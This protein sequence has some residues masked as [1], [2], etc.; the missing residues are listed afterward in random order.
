MLAAYVGFKTLGMVGAVV[1]AVAV[2]LPSFAMMFA[3]L[4][5]FER[6]RTI[7]WARA[8]LQ[9]M[10]A[11]VIG[12]LA[13]TLT[14]LVPHALVDPFAVVLF[15]GAVTILLVWRAAPLKAAAGGAVLGVVRRRLI[16]A[17]GI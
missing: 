14:R 4:P 7:T 9:G 13:I 3:L 2:F 1:A 6:V 16:A 8:A 5:V 12:V 11:G 17:W 10:V 15:L